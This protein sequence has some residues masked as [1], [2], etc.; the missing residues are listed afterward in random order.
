MKAR[1]LI[2][3]AAV[4]ITTA[5]FNS[6]APVQTAKATV[7]PAM[8]EAEFA[9]FRTHRQGKGVTGTWA[10]SNNSGVVGFSVQRTYEDPTDPYAFWEELC[11]MPCTSARSTKYTDENV[12]PGVVSYRVVALL[13]DDNSTASEFS[14]VRIVSHK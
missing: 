4:L 12:F 2:I 5:S 1:F 14:S 9:F 3:P 6:P 8:T 13:S 10:L 11:Y 7:K